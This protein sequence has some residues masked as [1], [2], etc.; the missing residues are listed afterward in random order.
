MHAGDRPVVS[1]SAKK[2]KKVGEAI[3]NILGAYSLGA[4]SLGLH[5]SG[6]T[7]Y[8]RLKLGVPQSGRLQFHSTDFGASEPLTNSLG[9]DSL[10]AYSLEAHSASGN[11]FEIQQTKRLFLRKDIKDL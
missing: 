2:K 5:Q 11:R 1:T 3:A 10:G 4:Y 6:S 9:A 8:A 7:Q